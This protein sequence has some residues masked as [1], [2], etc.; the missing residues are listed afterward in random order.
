[1]CFIKTRLDSL[2]HNV[3][4]WETKIDGE[5]KTNTTGKCQLALLLPRIA[6]CQLNLAFTAQTFPFADTYLFVSVVIAAS[7]PCNFDSYL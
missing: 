1:M 7:E 5:E 3:A 6:A 4:H 2:H